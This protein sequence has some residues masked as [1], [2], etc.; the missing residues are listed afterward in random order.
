MKAETKTSSGSRTVYASLYQI[1]DQKKL[2][3]HVIFIVD[4]KGELEGQIAGPVTIGAW[5]LPRITRK[6]AAQIVRDYLKEE[7]PHKNIHVEDIK[8][9]SS[10]KAN[11]L[12]FK[13]E[14]K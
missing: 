8:L 7:H 3:A 4:K 10:K 11:E 5:Y 6:E 14:N 13:L 1:S 12:L 9:Y 2:K